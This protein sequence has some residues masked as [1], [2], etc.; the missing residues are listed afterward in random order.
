[1]D[2]TGRVKGAAPSPVEDPRACV[3]PTRIMA[4]VDYTEEP[5]LG[6]GRRTDERAS[7]RLTFVMRSLPRKSLK[8]GVL[9][10]QRD[11]KSRRSFAKWSVS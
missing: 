4:A 3:L 9:V 7:Q 1:M 6:L 2:L 10:L 8:S 11:G 5:A